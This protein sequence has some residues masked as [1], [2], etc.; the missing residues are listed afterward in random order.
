MI[1]DT[2]VHLDVKQYHNDID[3][4]LGTAR[5]AGVKRFIIPA[6]ESDN[7]VGILHLVNKHEDIFFSTG[8][9]PNRMNHFNLQLIERHLSHEKCVAIG[10]CGL[11]WY[12]IQ[13]G[14]NINDV[15][16]AQKKVFEQ[17]LEL[18]AKWRKP[19]ILH[20]RDTDLEM[21]ES[22]SKFGHDLVGGVVHCFLGSKKLLELE[23]F[24]FYFG[25]GGVL[26]YDKTGLLENTLK[27]M[28]INRI[29]LET[30]GPYLTPV[31]HRGERNEPAYTRYVLN[32][33]AFILKKDIK[34]L[35]NKIENNVNNL[36]FK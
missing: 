28:D 36:F 25:I 9:H 5:D 6:I 2:H 15:K 27:S 33:I 35:E 7:M 4:V 10:E 34:E 16:A 31:P 17:Q 29:I 12:R 11:D 18:A 14:S 22:V 24:N 21:V 30:D 8:N 3:R 1:T 19:V 13:P 26:T 20:S 32:K 23:K